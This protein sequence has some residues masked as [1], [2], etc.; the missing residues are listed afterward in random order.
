MSRHH[1]LSEVKKA[2]ETYHGCVHLAAESLGVW[3][4]AVYA[5]IG[6][7]PQLKELVEAYG[8]RLLDLA[9]LKLEQAIR[10]G[11][12]WA[13]L[14][15]LRTKGRHRGYV[16]KQEIDAS[17]HM[18]IDVQPKIGAELDRDIERILAVLGAG[19]EA[20]PTSPGDQLPQG[21]GAPD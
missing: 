3:P 1:S 16:E 19:R 12:R 8:G 18:H 10:D 7:S 17:G 20:G 2:L 9:E 5:R 21:F 6:K 13:I 14:F 4:S 11:E 15:L